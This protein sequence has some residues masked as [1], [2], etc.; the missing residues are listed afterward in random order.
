MY[1]QYSHTQYSFPVM[2]DETERKKMDKIDIFAFGF[3]DLV[4]G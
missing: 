4:K 1:V 3:L 2:L